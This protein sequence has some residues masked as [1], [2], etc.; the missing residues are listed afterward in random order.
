MALHG[1]PWYRVVTM[2]SDQLPEPK[3]EP[4]TH[5]PAKRRYEPPRVES[6]QLSPDAV[7]APT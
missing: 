7:E 2:Q 1:A 4:T 3:D 6:I 5:A